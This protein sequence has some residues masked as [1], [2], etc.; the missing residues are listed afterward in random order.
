MSRRFRICMAKG[1]RES[2]R[3]SYGRPKWILISSQKKNLK[4][5]FAKP[6]GHNFHISALKL[7]QR[8][9]DIYEI[10]LIQGQGWIL[11]IVAVRFC[12]TP[13]YFCW[14]LAFYRHLPTSGKLIFCQQLTWF[15]SFANALFWTCCYKSPLSKIIQLQWNSTD[16]FLKAVKTKEKKSF[17]ARR[18]PCQGQFLPPVVHRIGFPNLLGKLFSKSKILSSSKL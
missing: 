7:N 10:P 11:K 8:Y 6:F 4:R 14:Q 17:N 13:T 18:L 16:I 9:F 5:C 12:E 1:G 15:G 2:A 3:P